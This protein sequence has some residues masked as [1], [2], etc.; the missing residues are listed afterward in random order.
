MEVARAVSL[1]AATVTMGLVTGLFYAYA[2]SVMPGLRGVDDRAFV[3][4]MQRINVAILNVWFAIAFVGALLFTG[5]AA[6]LH[7]GGDEGGVLL[8]IAVA[9]A[10]YVAALVVT[11]LFNIPLN[12]ELAAAGEPERIT[13]PAVSRRRFETPWVRW[14]IV[15]A[16]LSTAALGCLCWAL[17]L[18]ES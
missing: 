13:D 15:R 18:T 7:L 3:E 4:V 10:L 16:L 8:L 17:L 12:V 11:R 6:L 2:C 14:N 9:L 5:L 1:V